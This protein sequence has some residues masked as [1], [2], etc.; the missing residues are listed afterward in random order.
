MKWEVKRGN[1]KESGEGDVCEE[2]REE[3]KLEGEKR[4][5]GKKG[6]SRG[7]GRGRVGEE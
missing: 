6:G 7:R 3:R 4:S 1:E 2:K 5:R